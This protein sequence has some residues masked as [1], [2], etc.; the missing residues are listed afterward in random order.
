[1]KFEDSYTFFLG[2][3]YIVDN[4]LDE[5]DELADPETFKEL[6]SYYFMGSLIFDVLIEIVSQ[7]GM[8]AVISLVFV[9][10]WL[11]VNTGS[12]FLATVGITEIF[13]SIPVAWFIFSV[14]FQ[15]EYFAFLNALSIFIVAAIGADGTYACATRGRPLKHWRI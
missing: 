10:I 5:M 13:F 1:V 3:S 4:F 7:D 6:N 14:V 12:F 11:R 15:I 8:L 2:H 9:F